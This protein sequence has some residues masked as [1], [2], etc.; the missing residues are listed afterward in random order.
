MRKYLSAFLLSALAS[1]AFSQ[2]S[3]FGVDAGINVAN[4]RQHVTDLS[5]SAGV[6]VS[7]ASSTYF[8]K[9]SIRPTFGIFYHRE[10]NARIGLRLN[11]QYMGLG[12]DGRTEMFSIDSPNIYYFTLPLTFH[13]LVNKHLSFKGG[14][15][16]S[17]TLGGT[18]YFG[19]TVTNYF[20]KNDDGFSFGFEHDLSRNL[21]L[22][23]NYIF[24]LKNIWLRDT[25]YNG[26]PVQQNKVTNR[27]LQFTL[28][29]KFKKP[30]AQ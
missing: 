1:A 3:F 2:K 20:H 8:F 5:A 9:N 16:L 30:T 29:Y 13:Y 21:A 24:G 18:K 10:L 23:V 4:L 14:P 25:N 28:I 7:P 11:A 6:G 15:Y 26:W 12:C 17:F 22:S 27:A 19:Q